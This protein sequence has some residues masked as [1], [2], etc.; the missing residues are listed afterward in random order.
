M[1][2]RSPEHGRT[3]LGA[4]LAKLEL[5]IMYLAGELLPALVHFP[6]PFLLTGKA[7]GKTVLTNRI[8]EK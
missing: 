5:D 4:K 7:T 8:V 3:L 1:R 6:P 2:E